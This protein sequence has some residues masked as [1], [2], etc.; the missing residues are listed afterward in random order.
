MIFVDSP[1]EFLFISDLNNF[2]SSGTKQRVKVIGTQCVQLFMNMDL[3][4]VHFLSIL[5]TSFS[6]GGRHIF[7]KFSCFGFFAID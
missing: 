1:N 7:F 6:Q 5:P 3:Y 2:S 4:F